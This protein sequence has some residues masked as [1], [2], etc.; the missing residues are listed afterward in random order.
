M[1]NKETVKLLIKEYCDRYNV[2]IM[3]DII[4]VTI[5]SEIEG[6]YGHVNFNGQTYNNIEM[7]LNTELFSNNCFFIKQVIFHE[8]THI[9]DSYLF[10]NYERNDFYNLMDMYSEVHASE[11]QMDLMLN[12]CSD[13]NISLDSTILYEKHIAL[14][15]F[16]EQTFEH[17]QQAFRKMAST[18]KALE[19]NYDVKDLFYFWGYIKSLNKHC[20]KFDYSIFDVNIYLSHVLVPLEEILLQPTIKD[21]DF[22]RLLKLSKE[23]AKNI[24]TQVLVNGLMK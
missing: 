15:D 21:V 22:E 3:D 23:L 10:H 19:F 6:V 20:I 1:D 18:S 8:L 24:K 7:V 17:V 5:S 13:P 11:I 16:M 2:T 12:E 14:I 4:T 9:A